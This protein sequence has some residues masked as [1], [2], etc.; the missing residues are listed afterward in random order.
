MSSAGQLD[1]VFRE[2]WPTVVATL[3]RRLGDLQQAED[4]AQEAFAAAAAVWPTSGLPPK[5]GAWL[6]V[7][8]WRKAL[9]QLRHNQVVHA[10]LAALTTDPGEEDG[11]DEDTLVAEDD[12]L[13]LIFACCHPALALEV[14]VALTLRYV[15]GLDTR[16]IAGAFLLP[17]AT[18]AQRLVRAKRKIRQAGISFTVPGADAIAERL[19]G[20][21]SVIYLV[22]N[23]G[24][25]ATGGEHVLRVELCDEAIW[26]GRLLRRLRPKDAETSGLLAMMLLHHARS[27]ARQHP[28]GRPIA[29]ADQDRSAW[30]RGMI[31]EGLALLDE[32]MAL[33]APGPYQL[34]AAIAAVHAEAA[35]F[36]Q[37]DWRQ[38]ALLYGELALIAPS[39][40]IDVNRAVAAGE[41]FGPRAG[42]AILESVL[43]SG[44]LDHYGPLHAAH[45]DL[46][47]RA[48]DRDAAVV[49]WERAIALTKNE[50]QRAQLRRRAGL[51]DK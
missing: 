38:I 31:D 36:E 32:A 28:D 21:Q 9:D 14:R 17:E 42:L 16:A 23:E 48:G 20:V 3:A 6:T 19:A 39:P 43:V 50:A 34:Q 7:T 24:Y 46:L 4:A 40:V 2:E 41:A 37:T 35:T 26:L 18:L 15:A 11:I 47:D 49:S 45:A 51:A 33:R 29:L 8:A 13:R 27:G 5:P 44:A 10:H 1:Q 12:R 22:F 30:H 25:A